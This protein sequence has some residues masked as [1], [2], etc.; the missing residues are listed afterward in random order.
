MSRLGGEK[1]AEH[2]SKGHFMKIAYLLSL[3]VIVGCGASASN[4]SAVKNSTTTASGSE[5][6]QTDLV[7]KAKVIALQTAQFNTPGVSNADVNLHV[8]NVEDVEG[9]ATTKIV[10]L[11]KPADPTKISQ[12]SIDVETYIDGNNKPYCYFVNSHWVSLW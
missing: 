2:F 11:I 12:I 6:D 8:V 5:C 9:V 10:F 3:A 7:D 4:N 1:L